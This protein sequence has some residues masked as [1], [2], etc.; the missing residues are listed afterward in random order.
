MMARV[1]PLIL[2]VVGLGMTMVPR[3]GLFAGPQGPTDLPWWATLFLILLGVAVTALA[4][5]RDHRPAAADPAPRARRGR[6][7][8]GS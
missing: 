1:S 8:P 3:H 4:I 5:A 7:S 2:L 6:D